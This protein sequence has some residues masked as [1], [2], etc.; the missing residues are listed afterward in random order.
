MWHYTTELFLKDYC[1]ILCP[2]QLQCLA[3]FWR[4]ASIKV[5]SCSVYLRSVV[6][7][8]RLYRHNTVP[9]L[10]GDPK[11]SKRGPNFEKIGDLLWNKKGTIK[12]W[13][14]SIYLRSVVFYFRLYRTAILGSVYIRIA[15]RHMHCS[16]NLWGLSSIEIGK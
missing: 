16:Q 4:Q 11:Y 13:S 12:V 15:Q 7:F 5:W 3:R 14:C 8:L 6:F 1:S 10:E 9:I 2:S